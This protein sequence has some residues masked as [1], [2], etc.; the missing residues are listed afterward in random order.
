M[1]E[2]R[3]YILRVV[4]GKERSVK[5]YLEK[6]IVINNL[7][8]YFGQ[9]INPT[10]KV[11]QIRK[12][13]DGKTKKVAVE[14]NYLP[15]Y[16]LVHTDLDS[17]NSG[18]LIHQLINIPSVIGF[19]RVDG[20]PLTDKPLPMRDSEV[21]RILG[22][23]EAA[24]QDEVRDDTQF[25]LGESIKVM[26]GPFAGFSGTIEEIQEEKKKLSVIV[27]IFGRSTPV[28]LNYAQVQKEE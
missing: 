17:P 7:Q 4:S 11:F 25:I 24:D 15:G 19:L 9:I 28:E 18:E 23:V 8:E 1:G 14:R 21:S 22:K 12:S 6:D 20:Q 5:E 26:E 10:E 2:L 13:K 27:K 16:V 3:W